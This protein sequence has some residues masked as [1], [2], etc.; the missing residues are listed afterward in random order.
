MS[1]NDHFE[2]AAD[3]EAAARL[4]DFAPRRPVF[5]AGFDLASLAG[6]T[7]EHEIQKHP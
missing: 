6:Y 5:T 2:A 7:S 1:C 4:V 3:W